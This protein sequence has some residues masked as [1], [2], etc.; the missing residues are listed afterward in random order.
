M[1]T[2]DGTINESDREN[3]SDHED[4]SDC[5]KINDPTESEST[6]FFEG[7]Q[8]TTD[9]YIAPH[10]VLQNLSN[11]ADIGGAGNGTPITLFLHG[12]ML[13]GHITSSQEFYRAMA[14]LYREG[15]AN[16]AEGGELPD[17]ADEL[18]KMLFG[19]I[20]D[21]IDAEIAADDKAY[22]EHGTKTARLLLT[23]SIFL[24]DAFYT[25]PG[26]PSILRG[27][28]CVQLSQVVGWTLGVTAWK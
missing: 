19:H 9:Y 11:S 10:R 7:L 3:L 8:R 27:Y 18:A 4:G 22:E 26:A 21:D 14:D 23:R 15:I 13:A 2:E 25:V 17:G 5:G 12:S 28:V 16:A 24:K 6:Q 20:A 1:C